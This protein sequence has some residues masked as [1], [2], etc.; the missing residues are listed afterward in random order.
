M[1]DAKII[2]G[3]AFAANLREKIAGE[4]ARLNSLQEFS[5][6]LAVVTRRLEVSFAGLVGPG[7]A[8][9]ARRAAPSIVPTR[10]ERHVLVGER[11]TRSRYR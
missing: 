2:D 3:K 4:V 11:G 1:A 6:G 10:T 9:G 8:T 5:P 7:G